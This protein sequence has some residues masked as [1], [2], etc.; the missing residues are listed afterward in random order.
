MN[1]RIGV[2]TLAVVKNEMLR[3]MI[4]LS[5]IVVIIVLTNEVAGMIQRIYKKN[6]M[7]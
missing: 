3:S 6:P 7:F 5:L 4:N 1:H 2:V